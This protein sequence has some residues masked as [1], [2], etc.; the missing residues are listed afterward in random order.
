MNKKAIG[1]FIILAA[2]GVFTLRR[3]TIARSQPIV[4]NNGYTQPTKTIT[5]PKTPPKI[6]LTQKVLPFSWFLNSPSGVK[7]VNLIK[8]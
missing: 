2:F 6:D 8:G 4:I 7:Q 1:A 3:K 5:E